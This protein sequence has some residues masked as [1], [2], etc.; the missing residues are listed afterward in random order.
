MDY[1]RQTTVLSV[2]FVLVGMMFLASAITEKAQAKT[3]GSAISHNGAFSNVQGH[4]DAGQFRNCDDFTFKTVCQRTPTTLDWDTIGKPV[5][6]DE[7]GYVT[8]DAGGIHVTFHFSNP[9]KGANTC[10]G[11]PS[12]QVTC[13]ITQGVYARAEFTVHPIANG[14]DGD[15]NSDDEGDNNYDSDDTP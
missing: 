2:M 3:I 13:T 7:R 6:G 12:T 11:E 10:R 1:K 8:A 5:G 15:A 4:L 14:H 9:A